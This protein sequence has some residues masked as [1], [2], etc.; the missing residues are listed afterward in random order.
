MM[1]SNGPESGVG[2]GAKSFHRTVQDIALADPE[3]TRM[4]ASRLADRAIQGD[5]FALSGD[6]GAGKSEFARAFVRAR[7]GNPQEEVPSPT[8]TL[9]QTYDAGEADGTP[10]IWHFD[11]YRLSSEDEAHELDMEDAFAYGISLIEWPDRLGTLL[12]SGHI[13]IA[14]SHMGQGRR[15]RISVPAD[16]AERFALQG[17]HS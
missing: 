1:A 11:L 7:L 12:H 15:A 4:L 9:V 16:Q 6:L 17:S 5:V 3:A 13:A 8:F 10:R 2:D 14:F